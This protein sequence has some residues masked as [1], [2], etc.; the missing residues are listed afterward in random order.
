[1]FRWAVFLNTLWVGPSWFGQLREQRRK[2]CGLRLIPHFSGP[3]IG[4]RQSALVH[5]ESKCSCTK[6]YVLVCVDQ[7]TINE[8]KNFRFHSIA[9]QLWYS[10]VGINEMYTRNTSC[11]NECATKFEMN[12]EYSYAEIP[13]WMRIFYIYIAVSLLQ[14]KYIFI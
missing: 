2:M 10:C 6:D 8:I 14:W 1:M 3:I 11:V 7:T 5:P 13:F 4:G 12:Y 9:C